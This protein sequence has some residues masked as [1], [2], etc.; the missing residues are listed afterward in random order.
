M[1]HA[2]RVFKTRV[3]GAR[4]N[5]I[6]ESELLYPPDPLE[7]WL[8]DYVPF[9][10]IELNEAVHGTPNFVDAMGILCQNGLGVTPGARILAY[11][12]KKRISI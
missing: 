4:I 5:R 11:V 6:G 12:K 10:I 1:H 3:R 9:P 8:F 7:R 2:Q